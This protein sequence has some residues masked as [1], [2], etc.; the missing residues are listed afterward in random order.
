MGI[1]AR[2]TISIDYTYSTDC[3]FHLLARQDTDFV[4]MRI[5]N[6]AVGELVLQRRVQVYSP[7]GEIPVSE[8]LSC[9]ANS[10]ASHLNI[11]NYIH[12]FK[13]TFFTKPVVQ[14]SFLG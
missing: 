1:A 10:R 3:P 7:L 13:P 11:E 6:E 9:G 12:F 4:G 2:D 14:I 5:P 8:A